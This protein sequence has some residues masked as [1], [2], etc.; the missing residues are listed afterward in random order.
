MS[1][2]ARTK[3]E[4]TAYRIRPEEGWVIEPAGVRRE[5][6]D[7]FPH[8]IPYRCLPMVMANQAGW[9][10]RCPIGFKAEW[11][12]GM[13]M[14]DIRI[15]PEKGVEDA[16]RFGVLSHFGGGVL[17]FSM[18][19]LFRTPRGY[20]LWARGP[21]NEPRDSCVALEGIVETDWA[22]YTFTM[23]W[24]MM[25]RGAPVWF[26]KGDVVCVV[27]PWPLGMLEEFG[28]R[29]RGIEE[30]AELARAHLEFARARRESMMKGLEEESAPFAKDYYQGKRPD[31]TRVEAHKSKFVLAR[32]E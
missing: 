21:V 6:M 2:E 16:G 3:L 19:W 11:N 12:G 14:E 4:L 25:R 31:G 30:D 17:T 15:T 28:A 18:P 13:G 8:R 20:G 5:W 29:M 23:N 26:K 7:A 24:K 32:F 9:A 1:D 10:I 22:P 27:T